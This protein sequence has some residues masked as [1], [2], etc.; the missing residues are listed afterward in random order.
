M[1]ER[2]D[3]LVKRLKGAIDRQIAE[4]QSKQKNN[5]SPS[6]AGPS[7]RRSRSSSGTK[8]QSPARRP[9][10]K[11]AEDT[12]SKDAN[13]D[14]AVVNPDPAVFEAAF[15][16]DDDD[17]ATPSRVATPVSNDKEAQGNSCGKSADTTPAAAATGE[18]AGSQQNG[19]EKA[20]TGVGVAEQ[21]A[22]PSVATPAAAVA[23]PSPEVR[24][25]LRKLDKLEKT[26]PGQY[27]NPPPWYFHSMHNSTDFGRTV[28]LIPHRAQPRDLHRTLRKGSQREHSSDLDQR[29][30]SSR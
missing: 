30:R 8:T 4:E 14:A 26:Y 6:P 11:P 9:R 20:D 28:A 29:P 22:S 13:G 3:T 17:S 25:R 16:I 18:M 2:A 5:P 19:V 7:T 21:A 1:A 23:E 24:A 27:L 10:K 15:V 12:A